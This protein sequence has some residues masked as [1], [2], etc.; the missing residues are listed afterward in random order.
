MS[1]RDSTG[2][3]V[4]LRSSARSALVLDDGA[5]EALRALSDTIEL[6]DRTAPGAP[7]L[8]VVGSDRRGETSAGFGADTPVFVYSPRNFLELADTFMAL[9]VLSGEES[10]G[11]KLA[12]QA[13]SAVKHIRTIIDRLPS[14]SFPRVFIQEEERP[15]ATCGASSFLHALVFEAGGKDLFSDRNDERIIVG[16]EEVASRAARCHPSRARE[17]DRRPLGR[18]PGRPIG[19]GIR[20]RLVRRRQ[21]RAEI[22]DAPRENRRTAAPRFDSVRSPLR[23]IHSFLESSSQLL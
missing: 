1:A 12:A 22:G 9:G 6:R 14:A 17:R 2:A 5:A 19:E 7:E 15:L 16:R 10:R 4:S 3:T 20:P 23:P 11:I 18:H 8:L 21:S 13:T